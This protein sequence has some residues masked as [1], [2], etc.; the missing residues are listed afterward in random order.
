MDRS[1]RRGATRSST[2]RKR[3]PPPARGRT[4]QLRP[5]LAWCEV[6]AAATES[7]D[8][9][10]VHRT[11]E[12]WRRVAWLTSARGHDGYRRLLARGAPH[13]HR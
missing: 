1:A 8:L 2:A 10:E 11:L 4:G 7:L 6:M 3:D 9:T 12:A 5:R 13:S